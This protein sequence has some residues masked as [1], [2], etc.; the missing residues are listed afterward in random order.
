MRALDQ[1]LDLT[2]IQLHLSQLVHLLV[3]DLSLSAPS[4]INKVL[5]DLLPSFES[6][7]LVWEEEIHARLEGSVDTGCSI[8]REEADSR[9]ILQFGEK[10]CIC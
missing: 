1:V 3:W 5:P 9:V 4:A 2:A 8:G 6:Q 10:Y 7:V